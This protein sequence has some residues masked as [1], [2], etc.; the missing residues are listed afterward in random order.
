MK[1]KEK[2]NFIKFSMFLRA[3]NIDSGPPLSTILGNLGVNTMAFCKELNEF[4][5]T[6]PNYFLVEVL[7]VVNSDRTYSFNIEEPSVAFLL[8]LVSFKTEIFNKGPGGFKVEYIKAL[9][10]KDIYLISLFK[11][12][13]LNIVFLKTIYGTLLSSRYFIK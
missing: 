11:Y 6:L 13:S 1:K 12:N 10:L 5:K 4:T 8:K 2:L 3:G 7:I 9:Q